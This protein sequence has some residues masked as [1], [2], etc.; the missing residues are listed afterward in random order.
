MLDP[1]LGQ[2]SV[3]CHICQKMVTAPDEG[4]AGDAGFAPRLKADSPTRSVWGEAGAPAAQSPAPDSATRSSAPDAAAVGNT[5]SQPNVPKAKPISAATSPRS[6][7]STSPTSSASAAV[8]YAKPIGA[9]PSASSA[10][11]AAPKLAS[12]SPPAAAAS[13][14]GPVP[15]H[16]T[17][18]AATSAAAA[19]GASV[20]PS[21]PTHVADPT[22]DTSATAA[23]PRKA[24]RESKKSIV[25]LL[26]C[27]FVFVGLGL[28]GAAIIV[29][30]ISRP[31]LFQLARDA[32]EYNDQRDFDRP[33]FD[34]QG[35][36]ITWTDAASKSAASGNVK[37]GVERV[38]FGP[39]RARDARNMMQISDQTNFLQVFVSVE[40]RGSGEVNYESWYG[41]RRHPAK[42]TDSAGK[43]YPMI[44][45][46]DVTNIRG[47]TPSATLGKHDE[48]GDVMVFE[49]P[50]GAKVMSAEAFRLELPGGACGVAGTFRFRIPGSMLVDLTSDAPAIQ[51]DIGTGSE[52]V[53]EQ[54][55]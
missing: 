43:V 37:V 4:G 25:G 23:K 5:A 1:S 33:T 49:I 10:P 47:H 32:D 3:E 51:P 54:D 27:L 52:A 42:L 9:A 13:V 53:L 12:A 19:P 8:P 30:Y 48:A 20:T 14:A 22:A 41:N 45:F 55:E 16:L 18:G 35:N 15:P 24:E 17:R 34:E 29:A 28:V 7:S 40:N 31:E 2:R 44:T 46:G 36:A 6:N 50:E 11:G 39:V 26:I 38:E 21:A